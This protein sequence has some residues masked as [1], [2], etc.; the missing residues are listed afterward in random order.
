[1]TPA[2]GSWLQ[3]IQAAPYRFGFFSA[4]RRIECMYR[5]LPRLGEA[6]RAADVPVRLGEEPSL[7][8][9]PATLA[10]F[11]AGTPETPHR[12]DVAFLGLFGPN[13]PLP[14]HLTEYARER[15]RHRGD[16]TFVAFAN[17]FHHRVLELFYRAW[18][19]SQPTVGFDRP[20]VDRY[21]VYVGALFGLG[22]PALKERDALP[23]LA[24]LHYAGHLTCQAR[25]PDGLVDMVRDFFG[26]PA[27]VTELVGEWLT[28]PEESRCR[29]GET[30]ATGTLG[31]SVVVGR[32]VWSRQHRFHLALGP[33]G[34]ADYLR[35]LPIGDSLARV[36]AMVRNYAGDQYAWD[37]NL[38]LKREEVPTTRLGRFGHLGWTSWLHTGRRAAD[39]GDLV[40]RTTRYV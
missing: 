18:A 38:I 4:L 17:V 25:H 39:A 11:R 8:F 26:L 31:E 33:L 7:D 36:V 23:D 1:V 16:P 29:L 28:L 30:R 27:R 19:A 6:T 14:L 3:A 32:E 15:L 24:K 20:D 34:L 12:L 35:F 40:L 22:T 5:T 21:A 10:A 2:E 37:L 13:G 9:A